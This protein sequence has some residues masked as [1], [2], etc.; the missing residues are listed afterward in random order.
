MTTAV[1]PLPEEHDDKPLFKVFVREVTIATVFTVI[2]V[3]ITTMVVLSVVDRAPD[4]KPLGPFPVQDV[5]DDDLTIDVIADGEIVVEGTKCRGPQ[6]IQVQG[7]IGWRR[8]TPPG[9]L[10][11]QRDFPGVVVPGGCETNT[12]V[13]QIPQEVADDVCEHGRPETWQII[14]SETPIGEVV[15]GEVISRSNGLTLGWETES[16]TLICKEG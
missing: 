9:L 5:L 2:A 6:P 13:D 15:S 12:F 7:Q 14:G 11:A 1:P 8:V 3:I 10:A 16:F 4:W